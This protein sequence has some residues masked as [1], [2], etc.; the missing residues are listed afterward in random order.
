MNLAFT[1]YFFNLLDAEG[2][3]THIVSFIDET[4]LIA[5]KV[6]IIPLEV[7]V[8]NLA[9]G[10]LC[11]RLDFKKGMELKPSL[12]EYYLKNDDLNDPI[13]CKEH[14][15]YMNTVTEQELVY[16]EEQALKINGILYSSMDSKGITLVDF[17][18]E[19][20]K[21]SSGEIILADEISPD[22]C[23][24]WIKGTMESLDKDV[25]REDKGDLIGSY[26]RLADILN[27]DLTI[28]RW[29]ERLSMRI[30]FVLLRFGLKKGIRSFSIRHLILSPDLLSTVISLSG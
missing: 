28:T 8:R 13:L 18:L 29:T 15:K 11:K 5:K 12:C 16:I 7:V 6:E 30:R 23:R 21:T 17:K 3:K 9:A 4:S 25:Y 27:L 26:K 22:T 19:F 2:I 1:K 10:S 20:G 14:I 24:F